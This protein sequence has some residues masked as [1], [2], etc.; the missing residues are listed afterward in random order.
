MIEVLIINLVLI[1]ILIIFAVKGVFN[2][3][4]IYSTEF[5][6]YCILYEKTVYE[7]GI[8]GVVNDDYRFELRRI[9]L[10]KWLNWFRN[11]D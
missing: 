5:Q 1:L 3:K 9:L 11:G 4:I 7:E 2:P 8:T 6:R 10:P